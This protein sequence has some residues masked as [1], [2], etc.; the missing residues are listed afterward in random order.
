MLY[1]I[2]QA[3]DSVNYNIYEPVLE[4]MC[5]V[6]AFIFSSH[7]QCKK[8]FTLEIIISIQFN[9]FC[10]LKSTNWN[11]IA[12]TAVE[13][14]TQLL[15]GAQGAGGRSAQQLEG[16]VDPVLE[17]KEAGERGQPRHTL[18]AYDRLRR[19]RGHH[20]RQ[21]LRPRRRTLFGH[22]RTIHLLPPQP[23]YVQISISDIM[24]KFSSDNQYGSKISGS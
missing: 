21:H 10:P 1:F 23:M 24:K 14:P 8:S 6:D 15:Q 12:A 2:T 3:L 18:H 4:L 17:T 5:L 20:P 7:R 9:T 19:P 11:A 13:Q 16:V 22:C